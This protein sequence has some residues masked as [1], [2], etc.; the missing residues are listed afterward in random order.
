MTRAERVD[1]Y[2]EK[3]AR[4]GDG[5][6]VRYVARQLNAHRCHAVVTQSK[7][8]RPQTP[9]LPVHSC[10]AKFAVP[11]LRTHPSACMLPFAAILAFIL[12]LVVLPFTLSDLTSWVVRRRP[13]IKGRFV[14]PGELVDYL[15]AHPDVRS[16]T[17]PLVLTFLHKRHEACVSDTARA[18]GVL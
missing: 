2:R 18:M 16:C 4:R 14:K 7:K 9:I 1:R 12:A 11:P 3:K 13:R 15:A 17:L 10:G 6:T 5:A 8:Q